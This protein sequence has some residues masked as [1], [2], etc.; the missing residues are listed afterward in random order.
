MS[1]YWLV[2]LL[3]IV[4]MCALWQILAIVRIAFLRRQLGG[5]PRLAFQPPVRKWMRHCR[6]ALLVAI[7]AGSVITYQLHDPLAFTIAVVVSVVLLIIAATI[8]DN[9]V[10]HGDGDSGE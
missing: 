9:S 4:G 1:S 3:V 6:G 10:E 7:V 2:L 8:A 5:Q